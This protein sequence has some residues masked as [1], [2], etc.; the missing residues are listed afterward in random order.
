LNRNNLNANEPDFI[1]TRN[2]MKKVRK[3]QDYIKSYVQ[4]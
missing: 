3:I 2:K 4:D 1:K